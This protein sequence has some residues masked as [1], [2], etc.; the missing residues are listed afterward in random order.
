MPS[1]EI[2]SALAPYVVIDLLTK[3]VLYR[4]VY[5]RRNAARAFAEKRN[6]QWG[7]HRYVA[8]LA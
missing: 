8:R 2:V 6:Q 1:T 3:E 7:A 5:G 4:T